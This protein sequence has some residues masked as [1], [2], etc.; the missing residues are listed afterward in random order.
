MQNPC[1]Q[2]QYLAAV[3]IRNRAIIDLIALLCGR[4]K[5]LSPVLNPFNRRAEFFREPRDDDLFR[6][7]LVFGTEPAAN[8]R[9]NDADPFL[10]NVKHVHDRP[11]RIMRR[12]RRRP[13][14]AH[15]RDRIIRGCNATAFHRMPCATM[16]TE[17]IIKP[18]RGLIKRRAN[19]TETNIEPGGDVVL[20]GEV[21]CRRTGNDRSLTVASDRLR[22]IVH[23]Y[24]FNAVFG[25]MTCLGNDHGDGFADETNFAIRQRLLRN[26]IG[27]CWIGDLQQNAA[28]APRTGKIFCGK[29]RD[30]TGNLQCR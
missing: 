12:L 26:R 14:C 2:A 24:A 9:S 5:M 22:I 17:N 30:D 8:I 1:F 28:P 7:D 3:I 16:N 27:N 21:R 15:L 10:R 4:Q 13:Y 20:H 18:V 6:I 11:L 29:D 19:V 25:S 23:L